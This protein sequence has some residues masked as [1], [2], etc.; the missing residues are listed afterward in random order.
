MGLG[1]ATKALCGISEKVY[2]VD[3]SSVALK[4]VAG[5]A[6]AIKSS[7]MSNI[8]SA[9]ADAIIC[10]LVAQHMLDATLDN[11]IREAIRI[12]KPDG[13][14]YLQFA[15]SMQEA[16]ERETFSDE[17]KMQEGFMFR[18]LATVAHMVMEHGGKITQEGTVNIR[19]HFIRWH[20]VHIC[21][22]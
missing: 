10:H 17:T 6:I 20:I 1:H 15:E 8:P 2:A 3:I 16:D 18:S 12:L 19:K 21:K 11:Q 7:K 9:C 5:K 22:G 14:F 4:R 13:V